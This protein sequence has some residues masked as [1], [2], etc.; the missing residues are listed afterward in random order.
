MFS[1][2]RGGECLFGQEGEDGEACV[3]K[4]RHAARAQHLTLQHRSLSMCSSESRESQLD[5]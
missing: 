2:I 1:A 3:G 5:G 4:K